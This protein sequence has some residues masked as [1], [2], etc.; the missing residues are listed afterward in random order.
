MSNGQITV[1]PQYNPYPEIITVDTHNPTLRSPQSDYDLYFYET[2]ETLMDVDLYKNFINY[3]VR[4]FRRCTEYKTYKGFLMSL[5][6]GQ[7]QVL[8][9]VTSED[10]DIELHHNIIGIHDIALM[11]TEHI[12]NTV[13]MITTMDLIQILIEEHNA[14]R[15][16]IVFL[17][18]TAHEMY[19]VDPNGYIPPE[20]TFGKFWELIQRYRYGI[21]LEIAYKLINYIRKWSMDTG[22]SIDIAQEEQILSFASYNTYGEPVENLGYLPF[23][24]ESEEED[25]YGYY[26]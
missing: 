5:G 3:A 26:Y 24:K 12:L 23:R 9:N 15:I 4:Q 21:T 16:P 10:A 1:L 22:I 14:N 11:I 7:C 8:G 18:E 6:F 19:T 2:K 17:S 13:G 20:M 25:V